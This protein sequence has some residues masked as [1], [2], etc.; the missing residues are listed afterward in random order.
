M[1]DE[2]AKRVV[3]EGV[4]TREIHEY[5]PFEQPYL[6]CCPTLVHEAIPTTDLHAGSLYKCPTCTADWMLVYA[7][8]WGM[9]MIWKRKRPIRDY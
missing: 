6:G 8:S 9:D 4:V 2:I 1:A 5:I 3:E 7:E